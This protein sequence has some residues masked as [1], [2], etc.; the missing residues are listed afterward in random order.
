MNHGPC[1]TSFILLAL[2]CSTLRR[3][4][5]LSLCSFHLFLSLDRTF[6]SHNN[7][8]FREPSYHL[9]LHIVFSSSILDIL[10]APNFFSTSCAKRLNA[11]C[12]RYTSQKLPSLVKSSIVR[13]SC[14]R[15]FHHTRE[16]RSSRKSEW[17]WKIEDD[18]ELETWLD[19]VKQGSAVN[20]ERH[21]GHRKAYSWNACSTNMWW[22]KIISFFKG[23]PTKETKWTNRSLKACR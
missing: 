15:S 18:K 2:E 5:H 4:Y 19:R 21:G 8:N 3:V 10:I 1:K 17:K 22:C 23:G 16:E 6:F 14:W 9:S 12:W 11:S 7:P 20:W 13:K